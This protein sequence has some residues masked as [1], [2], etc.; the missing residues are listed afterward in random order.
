MDQAEGLRRLAA[1][2]ASGAKP[3]RV[4][5]VTSGKG[6]VG[7]T[8]LTVNLGIA[9]AQRGQRVGLLDADFGLSNIDVLLGI[10]PR[11]TLADALFGGRTLRDIGMAGPC[12]IRVYPG[13]SGLR[14]MA[15]LSRERLQR[16][17]AEFGRLD[18][19]V[20]MLLVDTAA[21]IG[22]AVLAILQKAPEVILVTTPEPTAVTDAYAVAKRLSD[23]RR[24]DR[25]HL[26]VNMV[27]HRTDAR[28]VH[29]NMSAVLAR[30]VE[31]PVRLSLLG[32]LPF[33]PEV[34]RSVVRQ[35]PYLISHPGTA[36]AQ[37]IRS[38]ADRLL[39]APGETPARSPRRWSWRMGAV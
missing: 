31:N 36:L 27:R 23:R 20:D 16:L 1:Q 11:Y 7:K 15:D 10:V 30:F 12:G 35:V 38:I 18:D 3:P 26:V 5:A 8:N 13:G 17:I 24:G 21:G 34:S 32:E 4:I 9:L 25:I 33:D 19:E 2:A 29:E 28:R 37:H 22:E 6:G 14:E 39:G